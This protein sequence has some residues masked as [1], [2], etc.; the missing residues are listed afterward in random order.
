MWETH[1]RKKKKKKNKIIAHIE[2]SEEYREGSTWRFIFDSIQYI[3]IN[4][5]YVP[6]TVLRVKET[7]KTESMSSR[8]SSKEAALQTFVSSYLNKYL[9]NLNPIL[10]LG[11]FTQKLGTRI[12]SSCVFYVMSSF[13][14]MSLETQ[15]TGKVLI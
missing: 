9:V 3:P 10:L 4:P 13:V 15:E 12:C 8:L 5:C 14:Y 6:S 11:H 7:E 2:Y 1:L